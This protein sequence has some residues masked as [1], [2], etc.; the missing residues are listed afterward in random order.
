MK[1]LKNKTP[2]QKVKDLFES[3]GEGIKAYDVIVQS[4]FDDHAK[5]CYFRKKSI[6]DADDFKC[7]HPTKRSPD[8]IGYYCRKFNCPYIDKR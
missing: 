8:V 4:C 7:N 2:H 3:L 5:N 1:K 6:R